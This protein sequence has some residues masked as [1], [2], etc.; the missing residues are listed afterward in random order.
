MFTV[1]ETHLLRLREGHTHVGSGLLGE[2]EA[3][4]WRGS[5]GTR[6]ADRS[7]DRAVEEGA[8]RDRRRKKFAAV[9]ERRGEGKMKHEVRWLNAVLSVTLLVSSGTA[10]AQE[11]QAA[12]TPAP[13]VVQG[14]KGAG[15]HGLCDAGMELLAL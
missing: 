15:A 6:R 5:E 4:A 11:T 1:G 2:V 10:R 9:R 13:G 8:G 3:G 14:G 7:M 12:R